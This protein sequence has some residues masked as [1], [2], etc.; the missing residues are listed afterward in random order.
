MTERKLSL[1]VRE[2][3]EPVET[4]VSM[5]ATVKEALTELRSKKIEQK[6]I[7]FYAIDDQARL[8]GVVS[9]RQLL[10]AEL[11]AKIESIMSKSVV[12]LKED[13]TLKEALVVFAKHPLL[14][15]PVIDC[16]GHLIGVVD[17]QMVTDEKVD[18]ADARTR[19]DIFRIVGITLEDE[20]RPSLL[21]RYRLRLPWLLCNVFSGVMCAIISRVFEGVLQHFL[22]LAFF[23]PLVLTL[24]ES[25]SMQ[26]MTQSLLFLRRPKFRWSVA[27]PRGIKE[28]QLA[29]FVA[30]TLGT[31]VGGLSLLWEGGLLASLCIGIGIFFSVILSVIFGLSV[32]V[33]LH[34][35]NLDPKVAAGPVVLMIADILTTAFYLG[36]STLVLL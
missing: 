12:S 33:F 23:I 36:L 27:I 2:C 7:Y 31:L 24:S 10:L 34:R 4:V 32:P 20:K 3:I 13:D 35:M 22:L 16:E 25:T 17:V 29:I 5:N 9:T 8:K 30:L 14:A 11:D 6:F 21:Y 18:A 15:I 19:L 28:C 1:P 26:S